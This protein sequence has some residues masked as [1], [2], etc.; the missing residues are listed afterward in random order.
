[1]KVTYALYLSPCHI[2]FTRFLFFPWKPSNIVV[3]T[4]LCYSTFLSPFVAYE[5]NYLIC[6]LEIMEALLKACNSMDQ[7]SKKVRKFYLSFTLLF[8]KLRCILKHLVA[9]NL[10]FPMNPKKDFSN[11]YTGLGKRKFCNHSFC[12]QVFSF[13]GLSPLSTSWPSQ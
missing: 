5:T 9:L 12:P 13:N 6:Q 1:M 3:L 10:S 4:P 8:T 2:Y 11:F 7:L